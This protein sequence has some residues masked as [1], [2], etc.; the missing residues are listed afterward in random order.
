MLL[1]EWIRVGKLKADWITMA[2]ESNSPINER[3]LLKWGFKNS[4]TSYLLEVN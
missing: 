4:E 3:I 1:N 2:I